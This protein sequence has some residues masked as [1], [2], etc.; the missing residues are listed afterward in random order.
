MTDSSR[1][2]RRV[3]SGR[4]RRVPSYTRTRGDKTVNPSQLVPMA[5]LEAFDTLLRLDGAEAEACGV[6]RTEIAW[7]LLR[8]AFEVKRSEIGEDAGEWLARSAA[9][10]VLV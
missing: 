10:Y 3:K 8:L 1:E 2:G 4:V 6:T 9:A 7:T 5:P